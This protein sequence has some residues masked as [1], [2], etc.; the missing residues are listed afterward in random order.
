MTTITTQLENTLRMNIISILGRDKTLLGGQASMVAVVFVQHLHT[1]LEGN[2]TWESRFEAELHETRLNG[3]LVVFAEGE[4]IQHLVN[5]N[6]IAELGGI[7]FAGDALTRAI[8]TI[9]SSYA[10]NLASTGVESRRRGYAQIQT[11]PLFVEAIHALESSE[12][13]RDDYMLSIAQKVGERVHSLIDEQGYVIKGTAEMNSSES[14]VSEFFGDRR[15]RI[16]QA[17]CFGPNGQSSDMARALMDLANVS[18]DYDSDNTV[19]LLKNEMMD[20][21]SFTDESLVKYAIEAYKNPVQF[22]IDN[23]EKGG[24]VKKP[25]NFVKFAHLVVQINKGNKPYIGVAVG[26]DAKGSGPQLAALMVA[27]EKM[28]SATGFTMEKLNDVYENALNELAQVGITGLTRDQVKKPYMAIFY[29]ASA[30]AMTDATTITQS[31]FDAVYGAITDPDVLSEVGE[32]FHKA[33]KDSF[34]QRLNGLRAKIKNAGLDYEAGETK[35]SGPIRH[36]MPDGLEVAMNYRVK[37][38]M[39]GEVI[40]NNEV[41]GNVLITNTDASVTFRN[42]SIATDEYDVANFARTGFVNM[43]QATDALLARLIVVH[44]KRL[45]AQHIVAIHDCFR[46][47]IHDMDILKQAIKNAYLDMFGSDRNVKTDDLPL[48]TDILGMYFQGVSKVT[49]PE[50]TAAAGSQFFGRDSIRRLDRVNNMSITKLIEDLGATK[51][52]S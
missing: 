46:V 23:I 6:Y 3:Q 9:R 24:D 19:K 30:A 51:Y 21:G 27:D 17:A 41:S 10:P 29:G 2:S 52:F 22:I 31:T 48:G 40:S 50:F 42:M 5:I 20:M 28:L 47:N 43:I 39:F 15:G 18:V 36:S 45:G 14:Y 16:Y 13:T 38:D 37:L 7:Y 33:I 8:D 25:W 12:F 49:K 26:L 34:G 4:V 1:L 44:A 11:S 32:V 35:L